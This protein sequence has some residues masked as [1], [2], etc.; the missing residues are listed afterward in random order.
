MRIGRIGEHGF[1]CERTR[2]RPKE[3][4]MSFLACILLAVAADGPARDSEI[5]VVWKSRAPAKGAAMAVAFSPDGKLVAAAVGEE[6]VLWR[7]NDGTPVRVIHEPQ[8]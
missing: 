6:F 3:P 4:T 2:Q 5:E 8:T 1:P 7:A